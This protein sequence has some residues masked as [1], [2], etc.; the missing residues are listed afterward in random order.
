MDLRPG[1]GHAA[2]IPLVSH[3]FLASPPAVAVGTQI[4][5]GDCGPC[6]YLWRHKYNISVWELYNQINDPLV[7][8]S[9]LLQLSN[10]IDGSYA[11][12]TDFVDYLTTCA[13]TFLGPLGPP[14]LL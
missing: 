1:W 7:K 2:P 11:D 4:H 3:P 6:R 8:T 9:D 5:Q 12:P 14:S 10:S 13:L